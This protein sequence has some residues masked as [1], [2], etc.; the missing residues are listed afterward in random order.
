M[1]KR[2]ADLLFLAVYNLIAFKIVTAYPNM[3]TVM[4]IVIAFMLSIVLYTEVRDIIMNKKRN[5]KIDNS[6]IF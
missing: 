3:W 5:N 2:T 4:F 1:K 6:G